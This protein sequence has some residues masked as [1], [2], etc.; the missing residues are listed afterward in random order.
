MADRQLVPELLREAP[1]S[2]SAEETGSQAGDG[3]PVSGRIRSD[4]PGRERAT[5]HLHLQEGSTSVKRKEQ[6]G[7]AATE[8]SVLSFLRCPL[9]AV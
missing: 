5:S 7:G 2:H 6:R 4:A 8:E 9:L 1:G 3:L